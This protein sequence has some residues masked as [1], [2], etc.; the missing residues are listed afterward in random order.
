MCNSHPVSY[1]H[2]DVYKRQTYCVPSVSAGQLIV[3]LLSFVMSWPILNSAVLL[4]VKLPVPVTEMCIRDRLFTLE[5]HHH[6]VIVQLADLL[7]QLAAV[8]LCVVLHISKMCIR[9]RD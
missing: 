5:V 7:Y 4:P 9:D 2:L 3:N 1:T 8:K 6:K